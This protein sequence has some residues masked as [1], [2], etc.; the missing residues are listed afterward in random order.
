MYQHGEL[1]SGVSHGQGCLDLLMDYLEK[2][3]ESVLKSSFF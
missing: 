3:C 2:Y 1:G